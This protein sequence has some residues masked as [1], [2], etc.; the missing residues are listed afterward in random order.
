MTV[1]KDGL[2]VEQFHRHFVQSAEEIG[3][4]EVNK[5]RVYRVQC[6]ITQTV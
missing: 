2:T 4:A 1:S 5:G 6:Q 3:T